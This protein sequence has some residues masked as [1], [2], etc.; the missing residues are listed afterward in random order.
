MRGGVPPHWGNYPACRLPHIFGVLDFRPSDWRS[1]R[2][3]RTREDLSMAAASQPESGTLA[4]PTVGDIPA[5]K[6]TTG[7]RVAHSRAVVALV[8]TGLFMTTLDAS[9]VNIGLP[10]I[11]RAFGTPLSGTIEWVIIGYLVLAAA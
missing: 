2:N 10:T 7:Q 5:R 6:K 9:I 3:A 8:L 11:A 1:R 4:A